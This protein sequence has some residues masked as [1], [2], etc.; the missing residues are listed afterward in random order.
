MVPSLL[1]LS[2]SM[3]IRQL[4]GSTLVDIP[5]LHDILCSV[6]ALQV[7]LLAPIGLPQVHTHR[8]GSYSTI[9]APCTSH[10]MPRSGRIR[11]L[12][13]HSAHVCGQKLTGS[14][15]LTRTA[16]PSCSGHWTLPTHSH[17][18]EVL[19]R[20]STT[21]A[22]L[23]KAKLELLQNFLPLFTVCQTVPIYNKGKTQL[24]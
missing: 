12:Y 18:L 6:L 23:F 22:T 3:D 13:S 2:C 21:N 5:S 9:T 17:L 7:P 16:T 4:P 10:Y 8:D 1:L 11:T 20:G 19:F 24:R 15:L 14:F